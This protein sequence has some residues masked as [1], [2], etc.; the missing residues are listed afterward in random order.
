VDFKQFVRMTKATFTY[1]LSIIETNP[2]FQTAT[3]NQQRPIWQQLA[4]TLNRFGCDGNGAS[5][6]SVA[7]LAGLG[8]GT[9]HLFTKRVM[10]VIL[11]VKDQFLYWPNAE[12][13]QAISTRFATRFGLPGAVGI[14]DG[15]YIN[16]Y[17]RP[18][19]EGSAYFN[20]KSRYAMNVQL[21]CDDRKMIRNAMI[22][23][24][25]SCYDNTI[26]QR[27]TN[28]HSF[29]NLSIFLQTLVTP[30]RL[31]VAS[32]TSNL[33]LQFLK[34]SYSTTCSLKRV[35]KSSMSMGF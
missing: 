33:K 5:V 6:V 34:M 26:W 15:T 13:R 14:I 29:R 35:V 17:H 11:D 23:W 28:V 32:P 27:S 16:M 4:V 7:R 22:G 8:R 18:G 30:I 12:E 1:I 31:L 21:V 10:K 3:E 9:I 20:R 2:V 24:P 19:W 25:G